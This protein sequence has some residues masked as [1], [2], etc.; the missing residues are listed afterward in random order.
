MG[1]ELSEAPGEWIVESDVKQL[2]TWIDSMQA[3]IPRQKGF[4]LPS[5]S[6]TVCR[7]HVCRTVCRR[8]ERRMIEAKAEEISLRFMNRL[9]DYL[10]VL[11]RYIAYIEKDGET[12]WNKAFSV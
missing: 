4:L 8:A 12:E 10:F 6:E 3:V 11:S 5:G 9:S 1:A 2:E 7:C